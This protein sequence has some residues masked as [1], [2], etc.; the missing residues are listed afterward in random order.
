MGKTFETTV[1][2]K[3]SPPYDRIHPWNPVKSRCSQKF[4]E[5][6]NA[7]YQTIQ[8]S[9][10]LYMSNLSQIYHDD[11]WCIYPPWLPSGPVIPLQD[12]KAQW[13]GPHEPSR[14]VK[15][16]ETKARSNPAIDF[17]TEELWCQ[18]GR[19]DGKSSLFCSCLIFSFVWGSHFL[20]DSFGRKTK[21]NTFEVG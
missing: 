20:W 3:F 8:D 16:L 18:P 10:E 11:P 6:S 13:I 12:S 17:P 21:P 15:W 1:F 9:M 19:V 2:S 4:P 14:S 7:L 5:K